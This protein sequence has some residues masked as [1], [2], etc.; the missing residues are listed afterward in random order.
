[1]FN[2]GVKEVL[3]FIR[4]ASQ[5]IDFEWNSIKAQDKGKGVVCAATWVMPAALVPRPWD[6]EDPPANAKPVKGK[7]SAGKASLGTEIIV[8]VGSSPSYDPSIPPTPMITL[9]P[10]ELTAEDASASTE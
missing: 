2:S 10:P 6:F 7:S 3:P 8:A 1:V 4:Y 5:F 9:S